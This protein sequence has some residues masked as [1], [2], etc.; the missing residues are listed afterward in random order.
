MER[1]NQ[2]YRAAAR[3][4]E[5]EQKKRRKIYYVVILLAVSVCFIVLTMTVFFNIQEVKI[6]G[7]TKYTAEEIVE[8][9]GIV[10]GD[11]MLRENISECSGN[12]TS[13]LIY[14]ETAEVRKKFPY[15]IQI[16]VE[17]CIPDANVQNEEGYFLIS[18]SGKI[19][20]KLANPRPGLLIVNGADGDMT[21]NEG[22]RFVSADEKK[23]DDIYALIKSFDSYGMENITYIDISD[24]ANVWFLYEGRIKVELGV[25]SE[26]DYRLKFVD[27]ILKNKIGP[28]TSGTLRLLNDSAQFID[29]AGLAENDRIYEQNIATSVRETE[30]TVSEK[31]PNSG[32][33]EDE[34]EETEAPV[35]E[36]TEPEPETT[37]STAATTM[38]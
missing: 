22:D 26:L 20:E 7:S 21:L 38:E 19:L 14:I 11:N 34:P 24:R 33:E 6:V 4:R 35:T 16:T 1:S 30:E 18:K 5:R 23:T 12:I 25:I 3:K 27:E 28:N 2:Q 10:V 32:E 13:K 15:T 8:A 31:K 17:P 37:V 9:S 36:V 29:E